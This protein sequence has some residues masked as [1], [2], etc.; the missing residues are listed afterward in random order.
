LEGRPGR[1]RRLVDGI[2]SP[3]DKRKQSSDASK[4]E[5]VRNGVGDG[6]MRKFA[7][8]VTERGGKR[9]GT[10]LLVLHDASDSCQAGQKRL[11]VR[12]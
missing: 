9:L 11:R 3:R 8:C 1:G 6:R 7:Q 12:T 5:Q 10:S 4:V 2:E